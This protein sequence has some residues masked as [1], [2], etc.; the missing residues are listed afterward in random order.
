M[1]RPSKFAALGVSFAGLLAGAGSSAMAQSASN[2]FTN[3]DF[4]AGSCHEGWTVRPA[5]LV[6]IICS[7]DA[8]M[9]WLNYNNQG[10]DPNVS[11]QIGNLTAGETYRITASWRPGPTAA[12]YAPGQNTIFAIGVDGA[13]TAMTYQGDGS[14]LQTST[15]D[16]VASGPAATIAFAGEYGHDADVLVDSVSMLDVGSI[17]GD[18]EYLTN[19]NV[20]VSNTAPASTSGP[21]RIGIRWASPGCANV[22]IDLYVRQGGTN[23]N[24]ADYLYYANPSLAFGSYGEDV[25]S[26]GGTS[27]EEV[28]LTNVDDLRALD[29]RL[30][31]YGGACS[32]PIGGE[33]RAQFAGQVYSTPFT[34]AGGPNNGADLAG[35]GSNPSWSILNPAV[36]F[37]LN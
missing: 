19:D 29:V 24:A 26:G 11:Q 2:L 12:T 13:F 4:Q 22:D 6:N 35:A 36:L 21:T 16:F 8:G 25:L 20:V 33:I 37:H 17:G 7:R 15:L 3:P 9:V 28:E 10:E 27:Y 1:L 18:S 32:A 30:N 14:S 23:G 31:H 5:D 34:L